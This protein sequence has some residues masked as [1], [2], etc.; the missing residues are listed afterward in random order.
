[1]TTRSPWDGADL[2]GQVIR[3]VGLAGADLRGAMLADARIDGYIIGLKLN[4][5]DVAP[6]VEAELD[7]LHPERGA[8]RPTDAA[9]LRAAWDVVVGFW[10]PTIERAQRLPEPH[11]H[12]SVD[13]EWSLAQ[14]LRHLVFVTDAWLGHAVLGRVAFHPLGLPASFFPDG[15]TL[16]IDGSAKPSWDEVVAARQDRLALVRDYLAGLADDD[17]T[18]SCGPHDTPGFPPAAERTALSCLRVIL[19]E[20]WAHHQFAVRDLSTLENEPGRGNVDNP[21]AD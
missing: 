11:R 12:R 4:G 5:V 16:G 17:V 7:R 19:N 14:T 9:G 18:A 15:A 2:S 8:L 6:L 21:E 10:R 1:M 13:G 3:E 20:E